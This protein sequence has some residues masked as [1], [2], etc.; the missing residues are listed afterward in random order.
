MAL[1]KVA[2]T[3]FRRADDEAAFARLYERNVEGVYR[4][5]LAMLGEI[6][7]SQSGAAREH[8]ERILRAL[9]QQHGRGEPIPFARVFP[10]GLYV[11]A[12]RTLFGD[13]SY[14]AVYRRLA[15][16]IAGLMVSG[17]ASDAGTD[18]RR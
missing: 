1:R 17:T 14:N 18:M 10:V 13:G 11:G 4:Y 6:V 5:S 3:L 7:A 16:G 12:D 2:P 8:D 9:G 15:R